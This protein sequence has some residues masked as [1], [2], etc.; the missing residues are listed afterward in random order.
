MESTNR[1]SVLLEIAIERLRVRTNEEAAFDSLRSD[2]AGQRVGELTR[3]CPRSELGGTREA[4]AL[5]RVCPGAIGTDR[6]QQGLKK[7]E[8]VLGL[9]RE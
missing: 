9:R 4:S 5:V 1:F 8:R 7:A 3:Q 6:P 2:G